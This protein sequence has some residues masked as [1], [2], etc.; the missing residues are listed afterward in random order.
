MK[1]VRVG[2]VVIHLMEMVVGFV[3]TLVGVV[4]ISEVVVVMEMFLAKFLDLLEMNS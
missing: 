4:V 3:A 1:E 2:V